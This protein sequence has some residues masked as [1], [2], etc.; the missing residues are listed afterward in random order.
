M[1]N[2]DD[3]LDDALAQIDAGRSP[4]A[5]LADHPEDAHELGEL[6]NLA[7]AIRTVEHPEPHA[8]SG[9]SWGLRPAAATG[10]PAPIRPGLSA[11]R[12][13]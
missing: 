5:V 11:R 10:R 4:G 12:W 1:N 6:L 2:L 9:R 7:A 13:L 3:R 8:A